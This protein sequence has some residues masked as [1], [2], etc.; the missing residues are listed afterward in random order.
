MTVDTLFGCTTCFLFILFY[1]VFFLNSFDFIYLYVLVCSVC[2][3]TCLCIMC[4]RRFPRRPA[5]G[6]CYRNFGMLSF[7]KSFAG[8][9]PWMECDCHTHLGPS[10]SIFITPSFLRHELYCL[11]TYNSLCGGAL[12]ST[13][14]FSAH[15]CMCSVRL[16]LTEPFWFIVPG[17]VVL[18]SV[19]WGSLSAH[20]HG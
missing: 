20:R 9:F 19:S 2:Q 3:H 16:I 5:E 11:S 15:I 10:L 6:A 17:S 4:M 14:R 1:F 13:V 18:A 8:L 12:K 7:S